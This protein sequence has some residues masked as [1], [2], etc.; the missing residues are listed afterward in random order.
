M[1]PKFRIHPAIGVARLGNSNSSFCIASEQ[2]GALPID[3]DPEGDPITMDGHEAP[4]A[5][6]KDDEG[7]IRRQA[8]RCRVYVYDETSPDGR[9]VAIGN[10]FAIVDLHSGQRLTVRI[11]DIQWTVYLANKKASWYAFQETAGEHGYEDGHPLRNAGITN[12]NDRQ[13]LIIDPGPRTVA[14][15]NPK[16]RRAAFEAAGGPTSFPPELRPN[17]IASLGDLVC[18]QQD[19]R[20]RLLVLGGF[21]NSGG[22][23]AGFGNPKIQA[24]ANNDGW[25]DDVSD[26][27][28]TAAFVYSLVEIDGQPAPAHA[29]KPPLPIADPAWV[30]VGYP[31][32]APEIS[33]VVTMDDIV[34]DMAVRHFGAAPYM[35]RNAGWNAAYRPYFWRDIWPI[36]QR[37]NDYQLLMDKD[38][39]AGGNP[40]SQDPG[41]NFDPAELAV[42]P[43]AGEDPAAQQ[44]RRMA[45]Q[46]LYGVLHQPGQEN[47]LLTPDRLFRMPLLCGDNPISNTVPSKFLRLTDTMLFLLA[48]WAEGLFID[49]RRE[50][51][52][53]GPQLRGEGAAL[54]RGVLASA[55]GGSFCPGGEASWIMRNPAIYAAPYRIRPTAAPPG[56]V[57]GALSQP[58]TLPGGAPATPA[59]LANGLE[60]GDLTKYSALPWQ[61]DFNECATQDID[62]TYR[63]WNS[64]SLDSTGDPA[65][66]RPPRLTYWWPAHRPMWVNGTQWS[67]TGP[68]NAGDLQMVTMWAKLGFLRK[69]TDPNNPVVVVEDSS[70]SGA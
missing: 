44:R 61:S 57:P 2:S 9:E 59:N 21:G 11:D 53:P 54:D 29:R 3:C 42:A 51:I 14:F 34:F 17:S 16:T 4:V 37:P 24:Y 48:Q 31:R 36:L 13:Q 64:I 30:I 7:R 22:M 62:V 66:K 5:N 69:T 6:F 39:M 32:Y 60:P 41:G 27:P 18:T 35:R 1:E 63:D 40:H 28:V 68:N 43:Y 58:A 25:F 47:E 49:E 50:G 15:Q 55:L 67:P 12:T 33:D 26:G 8:A 45:R 52:D 65:A 56:P 10:T 46:F 20:N 23:L 38:A 19:G 70:R